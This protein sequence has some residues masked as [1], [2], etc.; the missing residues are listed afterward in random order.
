MNM[1]VDQA[2]HATYLQCSFILNNDIINKLTE[3]K[4]IL[5]LIP[6]FSGE[7]VNRE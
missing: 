1:R 7:C 3:K 2:V 6:F 5:H 4:W